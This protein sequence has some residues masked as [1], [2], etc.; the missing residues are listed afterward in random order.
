M[1]DFD[2]WID[3]I[4]QATERRRQTQ[5]EALERES[6]EIYRAAMEQH[7][8][9]KALDVEDEEPFLDDRPTP[10]DIT[11]WIKQCPVG[12]ICQLLGNWLSSYPVRVPPRA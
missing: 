7:N 11:W 2:K 3:S 5:Y 4:H 10:A 12:E 1:F 8:R 6:E 9:V